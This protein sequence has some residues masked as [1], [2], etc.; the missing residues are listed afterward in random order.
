MEKGL[1]NEEVI[2]RQEIFGPNDFKEEE[3]E[4]LLD[5]LLEQ[6]DD[7]MVKLLLLAA[8]ISFVISFLS[9]YSGNESDLPI[10]IEPLVIFMILIA[11]GVIGVY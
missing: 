5:K 7:P 4:S 9:H 6:F 1:S 3:K 10:W 8:I 2:K 11:N